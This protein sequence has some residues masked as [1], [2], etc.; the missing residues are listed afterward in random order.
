MKNTPSKDKAMPDRMIQI[1]IPDEERDSTCVPYS[2][3]NDQI[4]GFLG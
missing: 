2:S 3:Q 4:D 1:V